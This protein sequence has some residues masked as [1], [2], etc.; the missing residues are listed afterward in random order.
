MKALLLANGQSA[1]LDNDDYERLSRWSW[2]RN[3]DGY[4]VRRDVRHNAPATWMRLHRV[5][6][7]NPPGKFVDH[8][9]GDT[10]DNR[11]V[12]LRVCTSAENVRNN[13]GRQ[14]LKGIRS[15]SPM[16]FTAIISVNGRQRN[17]GTFDSEHTAA[18]AYDLW[19]PFFY[20]DFARTN[21][22]IVAIR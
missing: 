10:L 18:L 5:V 22:P 2:R 12:N 6:M 4:V 3:K 11:R 17:I 20:G 9:N 21:F 16:R 1:L 15:Q 13:R 8:I 14:P 7:G 19:A